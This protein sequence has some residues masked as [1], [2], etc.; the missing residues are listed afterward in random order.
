[1]LSAR[2]FTRE[3][4][5]AANAYCCGAMTLERAPGLKDE[6][7]PVFDCANACGRHGKR[8]PSVASHI[9]MKAEET[10]FISGAHSKTIN[11]QNAATVESCN[12]ADNMSWRLCTKDHVLNPDGSKLGPATAPRHTTDG[13]RACR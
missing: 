9:H 7:L 5:D 4:G 6:H 12:A 11:R 13:R 8:Y 10:P 2:G 3:E 1:M